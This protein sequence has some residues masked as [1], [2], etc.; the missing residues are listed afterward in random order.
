MDSSKESHSART[1]DD[2]ARFEEIRQ[3]MN[4]LI[5]DEQRETDEYLHLAQEREKQVEASL[6]RVQDTRARMNR[7]VRL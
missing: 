2:F 1:I 3:E 7:R 4:F 6:K 5:D